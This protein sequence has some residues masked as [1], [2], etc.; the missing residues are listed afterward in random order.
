MWKLTDIGL[1]VSNDLKL[2]MSENNQDYL[3][4]IDKMSLIKLEELEDLYITTKLIIKLH[5]SGGQM[6]FKSLRKDLIVSKE[7]L[8]SYSWPDSSYSERPLFE[9]IKKPSSLR[10]KL[11]KIFQ[12]VSE[13]DLIFNLT[14]EGKKIAEIIML[15]K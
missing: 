11:I 9:I 13:D 4:K 6:E 14:D 3:P 1:K 15:N 5:E 2:V 12:M 7:K 8:A 10:S